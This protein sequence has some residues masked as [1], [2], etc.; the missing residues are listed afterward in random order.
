MLHVRISGRTQAGVTGRIERI[1][2]EN[3]AQ[4][5]VRMLPESRNE[6][7]IKIWP[8]WGRAPLDQVDRIKD[9]YYKF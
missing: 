5:G 1:E 2:C 3:R 9:R 6:D 7:K 4:N 8:P